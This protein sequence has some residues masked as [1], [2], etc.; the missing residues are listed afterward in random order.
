MIPFNPNLPDI[1]KHEP[2]R[3]FQVGQ[4]LALL[5]EKP[6]SIAETTTGKYYGLITYLYALAVITTEKPHNLVYMVTSEQSGPELCRQSKEATG[7]DQTTQPFLCVFD[8]KG[9]HLN[10][11]H[12]PECDNQDRFIA[13]ALEVVRKR[14]QI[15]DAAIE[16]KA[17][18][19]PVDISHTGQVRH[20]D[21]DQAL[22]IPSNYV[23]GARMLSQS[24]AKMLPTPKKCV[25]IAIGAIIATMLLF[26]PFQVMWTQGGVVMTGYSFLFKLPDRASVNVGQLIVQWLGVALVGGIVY[27]LIDRRG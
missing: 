4:Y 2:V 15:R 3:A 27:L 14:F 26:P 20:G 10:L 9:G 8:E 12:S 1:T 13:K 5:I 24:A 11:G 18:G 25:L 17:G 19:A 6:K 21:Q 23:I 16:V 7:I 22:H